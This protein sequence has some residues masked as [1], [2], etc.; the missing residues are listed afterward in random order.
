MSA[1]EHLKAL[2]TAWKTR[3]NNWPAPVVEN[4]R[5]ILTL[6]KP[7]AAIEKK[8]AARIAKLTNPGHST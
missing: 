3:P 4:F 5:F 6:A 8:V 2:Q 1:G 7:D